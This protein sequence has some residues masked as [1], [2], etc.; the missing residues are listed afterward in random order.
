MKKI[1]LICVM[2]FVM[3]ILYGQTKSTES[4]QG[5]KHSG[6][7]QKQANT[8]T[9]NQSARPYLT[10]E[11]IANCNSTPTLW[12]KY[13]GAIL[14]GWPYYFKDIDI[15]VTN[16]THYDHIE[17]YT[18]NI[19]KKKI[20][21]EYKQV[22]KKNDEYEGLLLECDMQ[23]QPTSVVYWNYSKIVK[24]YEIHYNELGKP[25]SF[26][27]YDSDELKHGTWV[28]HQSADI[29]DYNC[30]TA[31]KV[32]RYEHGKPLFQY[33]YNCDNKIVEIDTIVG[34]YGFIRPQTMSTNEIEIAIGMYEERIKSGSADSA[35]NRK[36]I[37]ALQ[38]E[39]NS[40]QK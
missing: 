17:Y 33:I 18:N 9:T 10:V 7:D 3:Q 20:A 8:K 36:C 38:A 26:S 24:R 32:T 5:G 30:Y 21:Y 1:E 12:P 27:I 13:H 11:Q 28:E 19:T 16:K 25:V 6:L 4:T 2:I 22:L 40:R 34:E 14:Y 31:R 35:D 37:F 39:M 15:D 23:G 29:G